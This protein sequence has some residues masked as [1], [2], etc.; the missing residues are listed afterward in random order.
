[1][2]NVMKPAVT[3]SSLEIRI[4]RLKKLASS[5]MCRGHD[6]TCLVNTTIA[7][8]QLVSVTNILR[9]TQDN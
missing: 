9:T 4:Y 2:K 6:W 3:S 1:M 8:Q 7:P 5:Y